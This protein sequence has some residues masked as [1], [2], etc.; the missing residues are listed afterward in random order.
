MDGFKFIYS[1]VHEQTVFYIGCTD[2]LLKRYRMHLNSAKK[3]T[4]ATAKRIR[5]ILDSG[6]FPEIR[7]INRL[8]A[9]EAIKLEIIL[10]SSLTSAGQPLT[11]KTN[12]RDHNWPRKPI[13]E[14]DKKGITELIKDREESA[15]RQLSHQNPYY[16]LWQKINLEF[17]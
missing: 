15:A 3:G 8:P 13:S 12:I 4:T 1:L 2:S 7:V 14:L 11:N 6:A 16:K 10:I 5:E 17:R 9:E